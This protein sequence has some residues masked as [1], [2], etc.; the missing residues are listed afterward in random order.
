M[1]RVTRT[2]CL[3]CMAKAAGLDFFMYD[4]EHGKL[5]F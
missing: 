4:C 5:Q 1:V 2:P 3:F